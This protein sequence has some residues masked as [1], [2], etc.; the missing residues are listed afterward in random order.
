MGS[1]RADRGRV[2]TSSSVRHACVSCVACQ[3]PNIPGA[4]VAPAKAKTW[5]SDDIE[6][7]PKKKKKKD[8]DDDDVRCHDH[9]RRPGARMG[10]VAQPSAVRL[11]H[12]FATACGACSVQSTSSTLQRSYHHL[13]VMG[14]GMPASTRVLVVCL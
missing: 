5:V 12:G 9:G 13:Q 14:E 10:T 2:L 4:A 6:S 7:G 3:A 8:L 11:R 1:L